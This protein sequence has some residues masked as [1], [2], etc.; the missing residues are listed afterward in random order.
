MPKLRTETFGAGDQSWLGSLHGIGNCRTV[1]PDLTAFT[2]NTH[3]PDGY[4]KSG[5]PLAIVTTNSQKRAVP[6]VSGGTGGTGVLA[7]FL[8]N[9]EPV[10][11]SQ[12]QPTAMLDHGRIRTS[13]LPVA[14]TAPTTT[15]TN[16][17]TCVFI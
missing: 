9:D 6:Y 7:G 8:L 17:T 12:V 15:P 4:L 11:G 2:A 16:A 10:V 5:I 3:Y 13:R 14:F 1:T